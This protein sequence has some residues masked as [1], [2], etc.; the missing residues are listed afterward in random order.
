MYKIKSKLLSCFLAVTVMVTTVVGNSSFF[1]TSVADATEA[2]KKLVEALET[3]QVSAS[4]NYGLTEKTKDGTI[5]HVWCW[6]FNTIKQNLE[7]IAAA[8]FSSVQTSPINQCLVGQGGG[9]E[10]WGNGKWNYHYQPTD[11]KIGNYQLGTREEFKSMCEEAEKYGIKVI[12]DVLPNHTTPDLGAVSQDL[13]NAVGGQDNLFHA[14]GFNPIRNWGD[15]KECTTGLLDTGED[16]LPDVNT[17]NRQFQTYYMKYVNDVIDCGGDG[18]RYD[19]AKHIGVPSDPKDE[20]SP[21]NDFWPVAVGEKAVDGTDIKLKNKEKLFI[22]G[23]VL[24]GD[25]VPEQEYARYIGQTASNYGG[26]LRG[27]IGG[28]NFSV[29]NI[30]DWSHSVDADKLVTW[31][32]SHDTYCNNGESVWMSDW[33]IK[34]CWAVIA[35]RE[36]GT[37]LFYSRPAGSTNNT[38]GRWGNNKIGEKGNDHFKDP[39]VAAVNKFRNAMVGQKETL[40]NPN[41]NASILQIDR[42]TKGTAIIN[43][44]SEAAINNETTMEDGVYTD[45][46]SGGTFTVSGGTISGTVPAGK[47]AVIYNAGPVIK[48]PTVTASKKSGDFV[49]PF[50]LTLTSSNATEAAYTIDNGEAIKFT[51]KT[52]VKIGEGASI[53][54]KI[55]VKVTA[56]GE[57]GEPFEAE[58]TYTMIEKPEYKLYIRTK[59]S[60]YTSAPNA[61]V[62][63]GEGPE[64]EKL[65][66]EWPGASMTEDGE[67]YIFASEKAE[68]AKI[69]FSY[70]GGQD[71]GAQQ[72]GYD[73]SG[74]MEYDKG[75]KKVTPFTPKPIDKPTQEPTNKPTNQPTPKPTDKPTETPIET[76]I[77]SQEP[78]KEPIKT[79]IPEEYKVEVSLPEGSAFTE[80]YKEIGIIVTGNISG[81]KTYYSVDGGPKKEFNGSAKVILGKG[82]IAD[83]NVTLDVYRGDNKETFTYFKQFDADKV[84]V[85]AGSIVKQFVTIFQV[86]E[87][88]Q[89]GIVKKEVDTDRYTVN[90]GADRSSPQ[91]STTQLNLEAKPQGGSAP[92]TY[93]FY[94][95]GTLVQEKSE[96][97]VC[98][99]K[100]TAG[101]HV[102]KVVVYDSEENRISVSKEYSIEAAEGEE[103]ITPSPNAQTPEP[104]TP[105]PAPITPKPVTPSPKPTKTPSAPKVTK[106][107]EAK[108]LRMVRVSSGQSRNQIAGSKIEVIAKT[109][110]GKG[111]NRYTFEAISESG[112]VI[113]IAR[114]TKKNRVIWNTQKVKEG[115]YSLYVTVIDKDKNQVEGNLAFLI[116]KLRFTKCK[117]NKKEFKRKQKVKVMA[118]AIAGKGSVK[119]RYVVRLK[120]KVV[121]SK[122]YSKARTYYFAPGK[123]GSYL[124]TVYIKDGSNKVEKRNLKIRVK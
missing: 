81:E 44:G 19:T 63:I 51:G 1:Y 77:I 15:R 102:I 40:R 26:K 89:K 69:I 119:Y 7:D 31:V 86:L 8:G 104:V 116:K 53:G 18:F 68:S 23:E 79:M 110:G 47:I 67:Y 28:K 94:V 103:P 123:K 106:K 108:A 66:G 117:V 83:S 30:S 92:Y 4:D 48:S 98:S 101:E 62:Y 87:N 37:P 65:N 52:T 29:N 96:E 121:K 72:P 12:V 111:G 74:Y 91:Y 39:E 59:K 73:I 32:E 120:N 90:F 64:A 95:N 50:E 42:G 97:A 34:M 25:G 58:F 13:K 49:E 5:L 20:K 75:S 21:E 38:N 122:G 55:V 41:G 112:K 2:D 84:E 17:E 105:S 76:P 107:P 36:K 99:W 9:M 80:E 93:E 14:N 88:V 71:P 27:S 61:Y 43:L 46:V 85:K 33:D 22:Y 109:T 100:P 70:D 114:N 16:K 113:V 6:S 60:D 118:A 56:R 57:E 10:L 124:I 11:W 24:Q 3:K 115:R 82:K 54:D 35:A 45:Q 78:T